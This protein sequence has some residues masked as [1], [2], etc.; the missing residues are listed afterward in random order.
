M[1]LSLNLKL[2]LIAF[3]LSLF[4]L[5]IEVISS[6]NKH[7]LSEGKIEYIS[8]LQLANEIK[9]RQ[10]IN[11]FDLRDDSSFAAFHIPTA[12]N[13]T[14]PTLLNQEIKSTEKTVLYS[15]K[16]SLSIQAFFMMREKGFDN[17]YVLE[18]GIQ[19]WYNRILYPHMPLIVPTED[20]D[21]ANKVKNLSTYF[22]GRSQ[23]VNQGNPLDY[24]KN[25]I[26]VQ[27][28]IESKLVRMGC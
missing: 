19:D 13:T 9:N 10:T 8:V 16:D 22:G 15:G 7:P 6:S 26:D 12:T 11:L 1:N 25:D 17:L 18:G 24:Y 21:L 14:P 4:A 3:S 20:Q 23:F 28:K 5:V 27:P 2:A